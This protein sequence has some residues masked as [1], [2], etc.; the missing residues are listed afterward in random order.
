MLGNLDLIL[1]QDLILNCGVCFMIIFHLKITVKEV[2][3][4]D[5]RKDEE[6]GA[7]SCS[8]EK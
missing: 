7:N 2:L 4:I 6:E 5:F 1:R 8:E 3:N